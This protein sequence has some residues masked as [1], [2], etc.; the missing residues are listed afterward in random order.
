M[1]RPATRTVVTAAEDGISTPRWCGR[2]RAAAPGRRVRAV[3]GGSTTLVVALVGCAIPVT[4]EPAPSASDPVCGVVLQLAPEVLAGRER[5]TTTSQSSRAWGED[6]PTVL[7]CGVEPPGPSPERCVRVTDAAGDDVD[8]LALE[9]ADRWTFL[10]YGRVPA[11]EL[12]VPFAALADGAQATA[13][14]VDLGPA[15]DA[16]AVERTCL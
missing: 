5:R 14:L 10:T 16:T 15:V 7:R 13:T 3:L 8:W 11:V 1:P 12:T 2:R 6:D 9:G 4:V